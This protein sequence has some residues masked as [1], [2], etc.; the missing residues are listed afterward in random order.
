MPRK[1]DWNFYQ[2]VFDYL[3]THTYKQTAQFFNISEVQ[4]AR[5]K[6]KMIQR[7][8][9]PMN[10]KTNTNTTNTN[11]TNTNTTNTNTTNTN[12]TNNKDLL[13]EA[14][15]LFDVDINA[16]ELRERLKDLDTNTNTNTD[17]RTNTNTISLED[18]LITSNELWDI[19]KN[20]HGQITNWLTRNKND[21]ILHRETALDQLVNIFNQ[22]LVEKFKEAKK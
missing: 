19:I 15:D 10:T 17:T 3:K 4:I 12:T 22:I 11:T 8:S 5:I 9:T 7:N 20:K 6:K 21:G 18:L 14:Y 1:I 16:N 13:Q 2:K